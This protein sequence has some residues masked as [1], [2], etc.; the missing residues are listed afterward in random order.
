MHKM[1]LTVFVSI[2]SLNTFSASVW[3]I[4]IISKTSNEPETKKSVTIGDE[5]VNLDIGK[6]PWTC[7]ANKTDFKNKDGIVSYS[8]DIYCTKDGQTV[9][10]F[11]YCQ[12]GD[13][14]KADQQAISLTYDLFIG[15][16]DKNSSETRTFLFS[17]KI[18]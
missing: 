9:S 18:I 7:K 16:S 1:L 2:F 14:K 12:A 15:E 8:R 13:S 3:T 17:C 5:A 4:S 10:T 11:G 6:F